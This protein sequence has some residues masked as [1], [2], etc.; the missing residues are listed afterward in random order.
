LGGRLACTC[1]IPKQFR[2]DF[3]N[4]SRNTRNQLK[5]V[6]DT[7][8]VLMTPPET[9]RRPIGFV[10]SEESPRPK[11]ELKAEPKAI[12]ANALKKVARKK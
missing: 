6:F 11:T 7:L 5:Q 12:K 4:F 3:L 2:C 10:R 1:P 8:R 9:P